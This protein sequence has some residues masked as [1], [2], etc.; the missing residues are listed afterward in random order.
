M[1]SMLSQ[2]TEATGMK[3]SDEIIGHAALMGSKTKAT[4]YTAALV[5]SITPSLRQILNTHLN[6]TIAEHQRASQ[7]ALKKGWYKAAAKPEELLQQAVELAQPVL[8]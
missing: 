1:P 7:L 5:E 8:K 3:P 2:I 6:E 4:A